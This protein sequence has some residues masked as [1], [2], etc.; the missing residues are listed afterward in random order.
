MTGSNR[1]SPSVG[2][3][4]AGGSQCL[5]LNSFKTVSK[6]TR[7]LEC[8]SDTFTG[9]A[10]VRTRPARPMEASLTTSI[11]QKD[12]TTFSWSPLNFFTNILSSPLWIW[13][14]GTPIRTMIPETRTMAGVDRRAVKF[15]LDLLQWVNKTVQERNLNSEGVR[16]YFSV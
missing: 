5:T 14:T 15:E 9:C 4:R 10:W 7:P 1:Q 12:I 11:H 3:F 8:W 16:L 2:S 13:F 6:L